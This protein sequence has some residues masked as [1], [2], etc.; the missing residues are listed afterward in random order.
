M[1]EGPSYLERLRSHRLAIVYRAVLV[2]G[3]VGAALALAYFSWR[4]KV[5]T[6]TAVIKSSP[7]SEAATASFCSFDEYILQYSKDGIRCMNSDGTMLWNQT[8]EM[9]APIV[10]T[11]RRVVAVGD[12]NGHIIHVA[13]VS[14]LMGSVDTNLPI[15]DFCVSEQGVVA[16]VLDDQDNTWIYLYDA[17]GNTLAYFRTTMADSG[18]P[19]ALA[20]SPNG[21]LVGVS[22]LY[23]REGKLRTSIA[24]YNFGSV[25]QNATDNYVSGYDYTGAVAPFI[26]FLDDSNVCAVSDDRIMFYAGAQIPT[27]RAEHLTAGEEIAGVYCQD[28]HVALLFHNSTEEGAYRLQVYDTSGEAVVTLYFDQDFEDILLLKDRVAIYGADAWLLYDMHGNKKF[29]GTFED[30]VRLLAET[31]VRNRFMAVSG[32]KIEVLELR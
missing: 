18:Y 7:I 9:Q 1:N 13:G 21:Q 4:D 2:I 3:L 23:A 29:D 20:I 24:F 25:G 32:S 12:Y 16:A 22:F 15:R 5:F 10:H 6:E 17:Q 8:Y 27:S 31:Q 19:V 14:G 26:Q 30:P 11:C 28:D